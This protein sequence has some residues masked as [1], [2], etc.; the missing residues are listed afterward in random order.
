ML[1][2]KILIAMPV[3]NRPRITELAIRAI[4]RNTNPQTYELMV[5]DNGSDEETK[6]MLQELRAMQLI[7]ILVHNEK[8]EGLEPARNQSLEM[9]KAVR[10]DYLVTTDNDCLPPPQWE[11]RPNSGVRQDWLEGLLQLFELRPK[12]AA[13]SCRT[14]V[15]IGTGNIFE[16]ETDPFT[17]FPHPGG[18]LRMMSV[19][20]LNQ[21][22]EWRDEPGRGAEER[23]ICGK[24]REGGFETGFATHVKCLHLFGTRGDMPTDRWGY[25]KDLQPGDTGHSDIWHPALDNGDQIKDVEEYVG[26]GLAKWYFG[27]DGTVDHAE[28]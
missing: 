28:T 14:Q 2:P 5:I 21:V 11:I 17:E 10:A 3:W 4:A 12:L 18:S 8:N 27:T 1:K 15:M 6:T 13:V 19:D 7:D 26:P 22:G 20:A 23:Y 24:L 16:D 25:D 9:A